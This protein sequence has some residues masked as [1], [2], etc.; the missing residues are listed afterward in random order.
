V[1]IML[2]G[3]EGG[4]NVG[5]SLQ[6]A[7]YALGHAVDYKP[8]ADA[9]AG[10]TSMRLVSWH[11]MGRR[12]PRLLSFSKMLVERVDAWR[13]HIMIATGTAPITAN[14]LA[15]IR[16]LGTIAINYLTIP[17]IQPFVAPGCSIQLPITTWSFRRDGATSMTCAS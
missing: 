11:L 16:R 14:A 13:P 12:P 17:G 7:A 10:P 5:A 2:V 8:I 3:N 1:K 4:T 15:Q 9:F 6:R